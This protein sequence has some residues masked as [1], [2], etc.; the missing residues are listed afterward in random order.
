MGKNASLAGTC[1]ITVI[2]PVV[3][4]SNRAI[5]YRTSIGAQ[6]EVRLADSHSEQS[7]EEPFVP[8]I[9]GVVHSVL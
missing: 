7:S 8:G 9:G 3:A 6:L 2:E 4:S 5:N 1:K